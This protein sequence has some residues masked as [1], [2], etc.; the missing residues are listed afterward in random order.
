MK[1]FYRQ[2]IPECSCARKE[3]AGID[4]LVTSRDG[5]RKIMQSIKVVEITIFL[6]D[7]IFSGFHNV[8][9]TPHVGC[10]LGKKFRFLC[11]KHVKND[12]SQT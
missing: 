1:E 12:T 5:Y 3:T 4:I 6:S 2:I 7:R 10:S 9:R 11:F 8:V